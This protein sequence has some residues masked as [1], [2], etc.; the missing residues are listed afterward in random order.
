MR[1]A[2]RRQTNE[3]K[4]IDIRGQEKNKLIN[5]PIPRKEKDTKKYR[6]VSEY[7]TERK[8]T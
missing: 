3:Q 2:E 7:P 4:Q 5:Q 6:G 8:K 1:Q